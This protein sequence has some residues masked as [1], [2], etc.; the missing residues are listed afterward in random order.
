MV[1]LNKD[2]SFRF[3]GRENNFLNSGG[4]RVNPNQIEEK[5][6]S[7]KGILDSR[8]YGK[9][10]SLLGTVICADVITNKLTVKEIKAILQDKL[11]KY[12][13]PQVINIVENFA[14]TN[15][16]KKSRKV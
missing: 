12:K 2:N 11:E 13:I 15:S 8:V 7:I 5:I 6:L 14:L 4:H 10:N 1:D 3:I 16:G 9:K